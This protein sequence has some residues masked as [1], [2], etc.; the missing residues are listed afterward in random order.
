M[1]SP[2]RRLP[3]R[4]RL[5][6]CAVIGVVLYACVELLSF[7]GYGLVTGTSFS[8]STVR[9]QQEAITGS[10]EGAATAKIARVGAVIHPYLGYVHV[11]WRRDTRDHG[12]G[13]PDG[14]IRK[15]TPDSLIVGVTGGSVAQLMLV[16]AASVLESEL[17]SHPAFANRR[18]EVVQLALGGYKQPQ[19]LLTLNYLE[20]IGGEFDVIVNLD[21]FNEVRSVAGKALEG[22]SLSFP[23]FWSTLSAEIDDP[24]SRRALGKITFLE[25]LRADVAAAFSGLPV[26]SVTLGLVWKATDNWLQL[27]A[28][29]SARELEVAAANAEKPFSVT[30][31]ANE[32]DTEDDQYD[33]IAA[34]WQ[35]ASLRMNR[36]CR[37]SGTRYFHFLQP[38]QYVPGS[39][40]LSDEER[41]NAYL[42]TQSLVRAVRVGYPKLVQQSTSLREAGIRFHD[43]RMLFADA[44]DTLYS[45]SCC[46]FNRE[47]SERLARHIARV[48]LDDAIADPYASS[49]AGNRGPLDSIASDRL[50]V[51][52]SRPLEI[53]ALSVKGH[54]RDGSEHPIANEAVRFDSTNQDS[55]RIMPHGRVQALRAGTSRVTANYAGLELTY[56]VRVRFD[57]ITTFGAGSPGKGGV[58]PK[59]RASLDGRKA[60][61]VVSD[62]LGGARG[63]VLIWIAPAQIFYCG[64]SIYV[65]A[66]VALTAPFVTD[67]NTLT[68]TLDFPLPDSVAGHTLY[69]QA[70]V[71]DP[72]GSCNWSVTNG[73]AITK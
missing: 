36:I 64:L 28:A 3:L 16:D 61:L 60:S 24:E 30:G 2:P 19:Q 31:P 56:R 10:G 32:Y 8:F 13:N 69:C 62:A 18:V 6:F 66:D 26:P 33:Y 21:G 67:A 52:L 43:L 55:V 51:V 54:Y 45:D 65:P 29:E 15:R 71:R 49:P 4:R 5:L 27:T 42:E 40:P 20:S 53:A 9:A 59:L 70:L 23:S 34:L 12:F 47:G 14:P 35:R 17:Q 22:I 68:A 37:G 44:R 50:E 11:P 63:T 73:V 39:K 48:I 7:V 25:S 41:A 46:H 38:N 1:P 72:A 58:A 57:E